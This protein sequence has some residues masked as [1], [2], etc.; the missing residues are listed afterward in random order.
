[1]KKKTRKREKEE[2]NSLLL[3]HREA[4]GQRRLGPDGR[5]QERAL[6]GH[7]AVEQ[8]G[9]QVRGSDAGGAGP[10]SGTGAVD[11][12]LQK[13]KTRRNQRSNS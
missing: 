2:K 1:M 11:L 7:R 5:G 13:K 9:R 4:V 3:T 12:F 10:S 8:R 6:V